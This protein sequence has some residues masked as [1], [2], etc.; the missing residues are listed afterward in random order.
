MSVKATKEHFLNKAKEKHGDFYDYSE[1]DYINSITKVKIICPNHGEFSQT[2]KIHYK[3]RCPKCGRENQIKL[4]SKNK[5]KFEEDVFNLYG[6]KY[7]CSISNY[8]NTKTSVDVICKY[9]GKINIRPD[10]LLSGHGCKKC[11]KKETKS[12]NK[13]IFLKACFDKYGDKYNYMD[14]K[15]I[16]S[17]EK[18]EVLCEEHGLFKLS[19]G[20]H[21]SGQGC[22][23]CGMINY[24]KVRTKTTEEFIKEA[25]TVHNNTYLYNQ[26]N[27]I[28]CKN[29]V[30]IICKQHGIFEQLPHNHLLGN[31]C[32]TCAY[33]IF[34]N[35][36]NIYFR[37]GYIK[38]ANG[39][40]SKVYLILC[41]DENEE[42]YKIGKTL[43]PLNK[44]FIKSTLPYSFNEISIYEDESDIIFDLE[45]KLHK[46][47]KEY[48]YK[49]SKMFAG[50]T[51]CYNLNL[52]IEE[53][54][55]L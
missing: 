49:P 20:N 34:R 5:N 46:K 23:K 54:I 28:S 25:N 30:E 40:K 18:I 44:R 26:A 6:D 19:I 9:H 22:P 45:I 17:S 52:P 39:R 47:Y 8:V 48:K 37:D 15:I 2:P 10:Y 7:D 36:H 38:T 13:D 53:I 43:L 51:E 33:D 11:A 29:K 41:S 16:S 4:A 12:N 1:V 14:T 21:L 32:P 24:S 50:Y 42:F 31:G 3:A 35:K 27:Y 55:N